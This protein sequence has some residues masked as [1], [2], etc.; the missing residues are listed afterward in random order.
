MKLILGFFFLLSV[1]IYGHT[2]TTPKDISPSRLQSIIDLPLNEAIKQRAIYK[3]PLKSAYARQLAM[4]DKAC[5]VEANQG[6]Q[7]YNICMGKAEEQIDEDY[8]SFYNNLQLLCHDQE[9][10]RTLRSSEKVWLTYLD[11][12]EK[13]TQASWSEG[14]GASGFASEVHLL[15]MRNRMRELYKIYSL[16]IAQ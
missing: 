2:Q 3:V 15:L 7:P 4:S 12:M 5:E 9:Q 14:T 13:A 8:A 16:N 11:A 1:P 10:L 6:Q